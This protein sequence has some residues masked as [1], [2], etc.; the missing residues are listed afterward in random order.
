MPSN[1]TMTRPPA[2]AEAPPPPGVGRVSS[3]SVMQASQPERIGWL[4]LPA[5][6]YP[7]LYTWFVFFSALDIMLTWAVLRRG[8]SEVNPIANHIIGAWGL[9][10][11]IAF[12]FSLTLLVVIVCEVVSRKRLGMGKALAVTAMVISAVP[13]FFSLTLLLLHTM[14]MIG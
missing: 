10:G 3:P 13:V 14:Q 7:N 1:A 11:A 12:K 5:M 4:S 8:G 6:R 9:N 2:P